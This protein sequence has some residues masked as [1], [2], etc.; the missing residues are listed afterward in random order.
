MGVF[1]E[2]LGQAEE[3]AR[4]LIR[5]GDLLGLIG[6]RELPKLWSR[7][8]LN[9]AVVADLVLPGETV[10]DVGSGA[11]LPGIPMAIKMPDT[12][13]VLI[14]PM[15]RRANWLAEIVVPALELKNVQVLR[16]RAEEAPVDRYQVTTARAVSALPK[17]IRMLAPLT[18]P[19]GRIL[20][21]K[22]SKAA[23]EIEESKSLTKK[24]GLKNFEIVTVGEKLLTDP[25]T[26]VRI[27][28]L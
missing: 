24:F 11:G 8:I 17:L 1:G 16:A 4:L 20:A 12:S 22:G 19:G 3:Y 5:D 6:P 9:S 15:E 26:V 18:A 2:Y 10:A 13:F 7:H 28:L 27:G 21:M 23:A 14:E 25:T